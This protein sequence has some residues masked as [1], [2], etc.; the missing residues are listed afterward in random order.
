VRAGA[1]LLLLAGV[2]AV[3]VAASCD[4][5][6]ATSSSGSGGASSSTSSSVVASTGEGGGDPTSTGGGSAGGAAW[7]WDLP[8]GF[9]EPR[10]PEDNPMSAEKVELGRHLF[11]D[12]RLSRNGEQSC[13]SCHKQELAFTDGLATSVGSTGEGHP[14]GSMMLGN[15]A[16][17][18][19]LTW[20][21]PV[22]LKL[23][24]QAAVPLFGT[25]P[26]ELGWSGR[27]DELVERVADD[28][29]YVSMFAAAFPED[30]AVSTASMVRAL[31]SFQRV[32]LTGRSPFDRFA[33]GGEEGAMSESARRGKDLF[34]GHPFEC[35]HCH[36]SFNL[37]DSIDYVGKSFPAARFHNTG[38]Y[39]VDGEGAYPAPNRGLYEFSGEATDM[40][41]FRAPSLRN[42]AVTAPYMHDG[43]V[44]TLDDVLDHYAAGGRT[45][46]DGPHAGVGADSPYKSSFITGFELTAE[47]REDFLA[48]FEALTDDDFL[49]DPRFANPW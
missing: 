29:R 45:I 21:N 47:Q 23:E 41:K 40:G 26:V 39:N 25:A 13:A 30:P 2:L 16:Y 7:V 17:A 38:L 9:P 46:E 19:A 5:G 1:S 37:Q 42:I 22:L 18:A 36:A 31:A 3:A 8:E 32:L 34:N 44:A 14:R 11:Y 28:E 48:F 12:A 27:E 35:F 6:E 10:V 4:D 20:S 24:T 15:V 49:T 43:S 33:Y